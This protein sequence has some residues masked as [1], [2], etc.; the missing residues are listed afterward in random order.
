MNVNY[1]S[2]LEA[3]A[4]HF[5]FCIFGFPPVDKIIAEYVK[6]H[7]FLP[8][9]SNATSKQFSCINIIIDNNLDAAAIEPWLRCKGKHHPLTGKLLLLVYLGE[10][11][12]INTSFSKHVEDTF[13]NLLTSCILGACLLAK[14]LFLKVRYGLL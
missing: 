4:K 5:F 3:E 13:L 8:E 12:A 10:C 9:L 11:S 6:A 7:I 2:W 14:G 1:N